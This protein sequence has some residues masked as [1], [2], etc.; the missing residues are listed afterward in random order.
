V[1]RVLTEE[2]RKEGIKGF[3]FFGPAFFFGKGRI[4]YNSSL[5]AKRGLKQKVKDTKRD[6]PISNTCSTKQLD[7]Y[8][9]QTVFLSVLGAISDC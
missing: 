7:Q 4:V 6:I 2:E 8:M 3:E 9:F 5:H 1:E